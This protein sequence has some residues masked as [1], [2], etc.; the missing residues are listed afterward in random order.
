MMGGCGALPLL[1]VQGIFGARVLLRLAR[2]ARGTP[3]SAV[4]ATR[5]IPGQISIVV[6]VLN[7]A[8]RVGPCLQALIAQDAS[9]AEI[10][11]VDG[12]STDRTP[13]LVEE[14][15]RRDGRVRLVDATPVP[16]DWNGKVWG[17]EVGLRQARPQAAW[18]LTIDADVLA[19]P[20]LARSLVAHARL[21][22]L[23]AFSVATLQ[24]L[25]GPAEAL[26]HPAFLTTLV[27][28]LGGPGRIAARVQ[29][30]QANGQ[31]FLFRR[32]V[33][34]ARGGFRSAR[35]SRCEDLTI[36]R[37][38]VAHGHRIGFY[39]IDGLASVKMYASWREAW[40][41]WPRSLPLVDQF[42][43]T[44][45][46][47]GLLEVTFVQALPIPLLLLFLARA[48]LH[49]LLG[50]AI[51]LNA[52]LAAIRLGVLVGTARAYPDRPSTYWFSPV[53]DVPAVVQIWRSLR[54]RRHVWRGRVMVD[55]VS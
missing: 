33:L 21:L 48:R 52:L 20:A 41:N 38:L 9:V 17:L 12:G 11:V 53:C 1:V 2:T 30:V 7:E 25:S 54:R 50:P 13:S 37:D 32:E 55:G 27:Y 47:L 49:G 39:E 22:E 42:A 46:V 6:P 24:H 43:R 15:A 29:S 23:D 18:L 19:A 35:A 44:A 34:D 28:R 5:A 31:C 16:A 36:A 10:L 45:S 3:I 26:I 51:A 14:Y 8:G 40:H 4:P